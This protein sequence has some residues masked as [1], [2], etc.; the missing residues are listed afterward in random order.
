[1]NNFKNISWSV[2]VGIVGLLAPISFVASQSGDGKLTGTLQIAVGLGAV[3][4]YLLWVF[5]TIALLV[6]F[7]GIIKYIS[8]SGDA[9]DAKKGK[10]IMVYGAVALF[11]LF[12]IFGIIRFLQ[13]EFDVTQ[14]SQM[15]NPKVNPGES[16]NPP[17]RS[18]PPIYNI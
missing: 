10:S 2:L 1:M 11:V 14:D 4:N 5:A 9:E 17:I 6:F 12:S 3:V 8:S 13:R 18:Q 15:M 16:Q 7:W